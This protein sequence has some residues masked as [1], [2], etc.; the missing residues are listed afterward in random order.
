MGCK[1][2]LLKNATFD[3]T[4][5]WSLNNQIHY[6]K[7]LK[8][9]DGDTIWIAIRINFII[10][11]IKVRLSGIDTPEMKPPK[12]QKNRN[13]EINA[14]KKSKKFLADL[15]DK[16]VIKMKCGEWDKYGRLLGTLIIKGNNLCSSE[17]NVNKLMIEKGHAKEYF[18][19]T[20][21]NFKN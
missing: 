15:V 7:V 3:N 16:K 20:K 9:Y 10:Y 2:T 6:V 8:V 18:G 19:G 1:L 21:S 13:E 12:N 4:P 11:K 5:L 14:A 17:I